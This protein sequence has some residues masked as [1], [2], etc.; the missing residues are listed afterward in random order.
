MRAA[1]LIFAVFLASACGRSLEPI[2]VLPEFTMTAVG[3]KST[4]AFGRKDLLGK[5]W[6]VDFIFTHC[7]GPCPILSAKLSALGRDLPASVGLLTV[8][9]DSQGDTP[10]R[11]RAYA[12]RYAAEPG[13]WVFL[14]GTPSQT[15]QL[16]YAGFRLPLSVNPSA[17]DEERAT[18]SSRFVLLDKNGAIQGYYDGL[19][20]SDNAAIA[21]DARR[22][23]EV[24][25]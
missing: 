24:G 22:L 3:P 16:L 15:Y 25:S 6:I 23:L 17:P 11:L 1:L 18:H 19:G 4:A 8:A 14:R 20:E 10:E 21:R 2:A 7:A 9:V 12:K 5:V 13:R